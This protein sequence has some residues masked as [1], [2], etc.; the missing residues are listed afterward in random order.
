[1]PTT[2]L[3]ASQAD[4]IAQAHK[5][6]SDLETSRLLITD[7]KAYKDLFIKLVNAH[8]DGFDAGAVYGEGVCQL[9]EMKRNVALYAQMNELT[10]LQDSHALMEHYTQTCRDKCAA[11]VAR[12]ILTEQQ[13]ILLDAVLRDAVG[14]DYLA[15]SILADTI[16]QIVGSYTSSTNTR[17]MSAI[18]FNFIWISRPAALRLLAPRLSSLLES[19]HDSNSLYF[20]L[21]QAMNPELTIE[22]VT[23]KLRIDDLKIQ[24]DVK[25]ETAQSAS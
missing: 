18:S 2:V 12:H 17:F 20:R 14:A 16:D 10:R 21:Q 5:L 19:D 9:L 8:V 4:F 3:T 22:D 23:M 24:A 13:A 11:L 6:C 7:P 1:M 25:A 15:Y